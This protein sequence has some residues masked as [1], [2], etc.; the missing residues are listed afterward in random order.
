MIVTDLSNSFNP[1]PKNNQKI[2]K[3]NKKKVN[4]FCIMP[5][6]LLYYNKRL[7]GTERHEVFEGRTK[8]RDYSIEDGLVIFITPKDHRLGKNSVHKNPKNKRW[9]KI[10]KIAEKTWINHYGK[11]K[12]EFKSRYGKNYL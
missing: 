4:D 11:T 8:N 9:I 12:E 2:K 6:S 5:E 10:R 7:P 1:Y 3:N